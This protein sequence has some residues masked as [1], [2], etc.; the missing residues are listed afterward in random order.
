[1]STDRVTLEVAARTADQLGSRNVRRLRAAGMIPGVLYG[2]GAAAPFVVGERDLRTALTGPSGTHAIVDVVIGGSTHPAIVKD[3]QRHPVR[4]T[5]THIDFHE[6]RLDRPIET[7]VSIEL[8]GEAPGARMG[9]QVQ[10]VT[11]EV[12]IESLPTAVPERIEV[13]IDELGLGDSIRLAEVTAPSGVTILDDADTVVA[14]CFVPRTVSAEELEGEAPE[15]EEGAAEPEA[16]ADDAG[17][18]D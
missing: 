5:L 7:T 10:L 15:G 12:R 8:T 1:M 4:G 18:E 13:S 9:G 11:R 14:N 17:D 3:V 16:G 6:V 2:K